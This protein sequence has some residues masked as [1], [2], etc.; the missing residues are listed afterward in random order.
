MRRS[1]RVRVV[2][3]MELVAFSVIT[4]PARVPAG[5]PGE[6]VTAEGVISVSGC[7]PAPLP[8]CMLRGDD[9]A[10]DYRL[11]DPNDP[12][13]I[14]C[15]RILGA[16]VRVHGVLTEW[17]CDPVEGFGGVG[18]EFDEIIV[19]ELPRVCGDANGDGSLDVS[20]PTYLLNYLFLGGPPPESLDIVDVNRDGR[21]DVSDAVRVLDFLF[22][23]GPRPTCA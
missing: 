21:L 6:E 5:L 2:S 17:V 23:G 13:P 15:L 4:A 9:G 14:E 12:L 8:I 18:I 1:F 3:M 20:D 10:D 11:L 22:R 16:R 7:V 19:L